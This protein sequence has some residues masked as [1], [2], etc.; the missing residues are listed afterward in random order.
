MTFKLAMNTGTFN[1]QSVDLSSALQAI[2]SGKFGGVNFRDNHIQ[3]YLRKGHSIQEIKNLLE[4]YRLDAIAVDA[5]RNWQEWDSWDRKKKEEYRNSAV[6][7]FHE[8]REIGCHC[9]AAPAFAEKSD[10]P[11]DT[12]SFKAMC[13]IAKPYNILLALEFLPWAE[14]KDIRM[15][16]EVVRRADCSNGGLL[17]DS[18]HFFKGGSQ[19]EDFREVPAEKIFLIHLNDAPDLPIHSKEMCFNHRVFP[20][21]GVFPL[22]EFLDVLILEKKYGGWISLEVLNKENPNISYPEIVE[23]GKRSIE[24]ILSRYE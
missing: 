11:E 6:Q 10:L 2:S 1:F 16:W 9:I 15:A 20:G 18:F 8:C 5:L 17:V 12:R 14:L 4:E 21:E 23:R 22:K 24:R 13:D 19:T 3:E 7:L